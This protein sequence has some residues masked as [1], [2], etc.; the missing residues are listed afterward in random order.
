MDNLEYIDNYFKA[1]GIPGQKE[2][3]DRRILENAVFA[4]DVAF[5]LGSIQ[6]ARSEQVSDSKKRFREIYKENDS[7]R[8]VKPV[9]RLWPYIA[10][11]AVVS[12]II[13]GLYFLFNPATSTTQLA[14]Q[15][16]KKHFATLGV[17]MSSTEDN[18]QKGLRLYNEGNLPGALQQFELILQ[19]DTADFTAKENAG[20]TS[21]SMGQYDKALDYFNKLEKYAANY[22]NP[23]KF[24]EALTLIKRNRAGDR[25]QAKQLLQ[26]VVENDLEGKEDAV[27]WL[28]KW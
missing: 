8:V 19:S 27:K 6:A 5:Y 20:I 16:I 9:R 24:Y 15:Y 7:N 28:E 2:E 23:A 11:A 3:F 26:Q 4:E 22:S 10:A 12:G 25:Q 18:M 1:E 14:D 13:F 17:K 21:L